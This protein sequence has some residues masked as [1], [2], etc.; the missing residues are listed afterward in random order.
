MS[1]F[2][3]AGYGKLKGLFAV[4]GLVGGLGTAAGGVVLIVG[5][6]TL[7]GGLLTA[8][9]GVGVINSIFNFIDIKSW[10]VM[11]QSIDHLDE[12]RKNYEKLLTEYSEERVKIGEERE[13]FSKEN[14]HLKEN[15]DQIEFTAEQLEEQLQQVRRTADDYATQ[16]RKIQLIAEERDR[17]LVKLTKER[18]ELQTTSEDF[19]LSL[20]KA[21]QLNDQYQIEINTQKEIR[22]RLQEHVT[23]IEHLNSEYE[24][25]N[26]NLSQIV[27]KNKSQLQEAEQMIET[28]KSQLIKFKQLYDSMKQLVHIMSEVGDVYTDFKE[29]IGEDVSRLDQS[30]DNVEAV[31]SQLVN[32]TD[33]LSTNMKTKTMEDFRKYDLDGDGTLSKD[34]FISAFG[35][36]DLEEPEDP[37]AEETVEGNIVAK[38]DVEEE[39]HDEA[40]DEI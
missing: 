25:Q 4:S 26:I 8:A 30:T 18:D 3:N 40:R 22:K 21:K 2:L 35:I 13:K 7:L 29:T 1:Y 32:I 28:L 27:E 5:G 10:L 11:K 34:E 23:Q 14:Q 19:K 6:T 9:G 17:E 38:T 31:V 39:T 37:V 20:Q 12:V 15:V 16:L 33:K 24:E 36:E